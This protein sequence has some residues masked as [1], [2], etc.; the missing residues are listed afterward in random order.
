MLCVFHIP[1]AIKPIVADYACNL[2]IVP[3][4]PRRVLYLSLLILSR[5]LVECNYF[6][7]IMSRNRAVMEE[8]YYIMS[9]ARLR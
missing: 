9:S 5:S 7:P 1:R 4:V 6:S 3:S 8:E 2:E